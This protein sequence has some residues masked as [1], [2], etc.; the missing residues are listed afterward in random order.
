MWT[1]YFK[2]G[3]RFF[4]DNIML[5]VCVVFMIVG[6]ALSPNFLTVSNIFSVLR[7]M[8]IVGILAAAQ[9]IAIICGGID[10]SLGG[11][12]SASVVVISLVQGFPFPV[13]VLI[14]LL[15]AFAFGAVT[16]LAVS[17]GRI[18]AFIAS[19]GMGT[20]GDGLALLLTEG[21]PIFIRNN[22]DIYQSIGSGYIGFMPY[23]VLI[24]IIV[25]ICGQLILS[26][27]SIGVY[28]RSIGGNE[29]ATYWSG[30]DTKKYKL[31]AYA[32]GG[33]LAGI[34]A[35]LA[36]SRTGVGDPVVGQG[37]ALDSISAAVLGGT[38]LGG[39]GVGSVTGALLGAFI[40][41]LINNLFKP[42]E[43]IRVLAVGRQGRHHYPGGICGCEGPAKKGLAFFGKAER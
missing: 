14:V 16:G 1:E 28:W 22:L 4:I 29:E 20:V 37:L 9:S 15:F 40:L 39:G 18:A 5:S 26:R 25:V 19:L 43:H 31:L 32:T 33:A 23:M 17:Y 3:K 34:A 30:I 35:L 11:L 13:V 24:F 10:V 21:R 38:Y 7:Q 6:S 8:S 41:G 2:K 42:D 27:T 12:L 36:V